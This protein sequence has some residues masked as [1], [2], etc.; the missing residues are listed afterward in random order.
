MKSLMRIIVLGLLFA[1]SVAC[2]QVP[3]GNVGV[4]V[5][6]SGG[7]KGV[8]PVAEVSPGWYWVGPFRDL[9][10]FPTFSQTRAWQG[11]EALSFS[12]VEGMTV[13]ADV[14]IT[15]SVKPDSVTAV[16]Q[17]YRRGIDEIE[18]VF[19]HNM[20]RDALVI[21]A[22]TKPIEYVYGKGK[23]ELIEQV[24]QHVRRQTDGIGI[25]VENIYWAGA[26]RLPEQVAASLNAKMAATQM[27]QQRENEIKTAEAEAQKAVAQAKGEADSRLLVAKAEAEAIRI[28]GDALREN[29]RLV[30]LQAVEKW[31]GVLPQYMMGGNTT[32]FITVP[33]GN[34]QQ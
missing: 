33:T 24:L 6:L 30:E 12:T 5:N 3:P 27:A 4:M 31:D 13:T 29:P 17:K 34:K 14:G 7:D 1:C 16:F 23:A 22:S 15:F 8:S 2:T 20:V 11:G 26:F 10:L 32:P 9:Y 28:R 25:N 18:G 21:E 19:L